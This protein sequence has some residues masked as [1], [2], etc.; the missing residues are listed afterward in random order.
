MIDC[1]VFVK[2]TFVKVILATAALVQIV[3]TW[4]ISEWLRQEMELQITGSE[5]QSVSDDGHFQTL[6]LYCNASTTVGTSFFYLYC[7]LT[8]I[9]LTLLYSAL[10]LCSVRDNC[11]V[12][13]VISK[14]SECR[15]N[16]GSPIDGAHPSPKTDRDNLI[17]D[18]LGH[19]CPKTFEMA[20]GQKEKWCRRESN[21]G[22]LA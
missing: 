10:L 5:K 4:K 8:T 14:E 7:H 11:C 21:P 1:Y 3:G 6:G 13:V 17:N 22:P 20:K 19:Y 9:P 16:I 12:C 2:A 15:R 18:I